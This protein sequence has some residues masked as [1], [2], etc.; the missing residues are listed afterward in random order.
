MGSV[1]ESMERTAILR[2]LL[3]ATPPISDW[4]AP[5]AGASVD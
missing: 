4:A 2:Q 3:V 5:K 1:R